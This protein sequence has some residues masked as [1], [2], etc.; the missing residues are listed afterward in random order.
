MD[1]PQPLPD[2]DM[3]KHQLYIKDHEIMSLQAELERRIQQNEGMAL[4]MERLEKTVAACFDRLLRRM[5]RTIDDSGSR[6][7]RRRR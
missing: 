2:L 4:A 5:D 6:N 3:L 1:E 7:K